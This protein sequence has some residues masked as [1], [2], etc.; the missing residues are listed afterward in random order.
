MPLVAAR[1]VRLHAIAVARLEAGGKRAVLAAARVRVGR[2][3]VPVLLVRLL[4]TGWGRRSMSG[5]VLGSV[6]ADVL[7]GSVG[8][9][10]PGSPVGGDEGSGGV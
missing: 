10:P 3:R 7:G 4:M 6:A 9:S 1:A 5:L 8:S 2:R